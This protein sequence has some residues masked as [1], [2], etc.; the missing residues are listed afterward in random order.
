GTTNDGDWTRYMSKRPL[1]L[2][3]LSGRT[4]QVL[5]VLAQRY[6]DFLTA[7]PTDRREGRGP[8]P[9]LHLPDLCYTA[10]T[11]RTHFPH[12]LALWA[13]TTEEMRE[14]LAAFVA[15]Q[16][17]EEVQVGY[18]ETAGQRRVAFLFPGQGCQYVHMARQL[19]ETQPTFRQ[20]LDE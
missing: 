11:G 9:S 18:A 20:T 2:L 14:H 8:A 15:G 17:G 1:H 13:S 12:R 7:N 4:A 6:H 3:T 19:Y 16:S 10:C 5:P